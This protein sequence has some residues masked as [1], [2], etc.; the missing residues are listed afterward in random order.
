MKKNTLQLNPLLLMALSVAIL[1]FATFKNASERI[2][3]ESKIVLNRIYFPSPVELFFLDNEEKL[4]PR[5]WNAER[6]LLPETI[7][8]FYS[9]V[10]KLRNF[11]LLSQSEIEV[12]RTWAVKVNSM[13][14]TEV[15]ETSQTQITSSGLWLKKD[16]SLMFLESIFRKAQADETKKERAREV[17]SQCKSTEILA[18][19]WTIEGALKT[20]KNLDTAL[21][22]MRF[23]SMNP[24]SKPYSMWLSYELW[25]VGV[26]AAGAEAK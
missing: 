25:K 2:R 12:I 18:L 14:N 21:E 20:K 1:F 6:P 9:A 16:C 13:H 23:H 8:E 19:W 3:V 24:E 5:Q 4:W 15:G 11:S 7:P 26:A 17:L 22:K 10:S